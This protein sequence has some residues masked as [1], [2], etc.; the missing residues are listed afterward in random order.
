MN[1]IKKHVGRPMIVLNWPDNT[2]TINQ[3][4]SSTGFSRVTIYT[5]TKLALANHDIIIVGKQKNAK[6]RPENIFAKTVLPTSQT[7]VA[8]APPIVQTSEVA[9]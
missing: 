4:H 9:V 8:V 5:K 3:I 2:F 1:I 7:P 6:G